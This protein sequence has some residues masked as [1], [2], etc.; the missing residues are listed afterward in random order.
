LRPCGF[1]PSPAVAPAAP[2]SPS[3][4]RSAAGRE[5]SWGRLQPGR[6]EDHEDQAGAGLRPMRGQSRGPR[7]GGRVPTGRE[8]FRGVSALPDM[9]RPTAVVLLQWQESPRRDSEAARSACDQ[10]SR[11]RGPPGRD[12][13]AAR[14]GCARQSRARELPRRRNPDSPV[15]LRPSLRLARATLIFKALTQH[16]C[17]EGQSRG[18]LTKRTIKHVNV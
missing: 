11:A 10:Q 14:S 1:G 9:H 15:E 13:E 4:V 12:S 3:K 18:H 8:G 2:R 6:K 17:Y 7:L 16:S 5:P